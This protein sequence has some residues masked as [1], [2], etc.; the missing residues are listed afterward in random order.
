MAERTLS[1]ETGSVFDPLSDERLIASDR[2]H[3]CVPEISAVGLPAALAR[4]ITFTLT[5]IESA[6][7]ARAR[8]AGV[9]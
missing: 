6:K 2:E 5:P 4:S 1:G 7:P 3:D 8:D 9:P